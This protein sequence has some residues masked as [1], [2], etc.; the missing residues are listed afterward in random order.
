VDKVI[1]FFPF[2]ESLLIHDFAGDYNNFFVK[3]FLLYNIA[4]EEV[5]HFSG[6]VRILSTHL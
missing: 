1:L 5:I 6:W 2:I 3:A 4:E